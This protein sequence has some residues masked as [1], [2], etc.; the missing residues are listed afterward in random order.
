[1]TT[2][3]VEE[4]ELVLSV[5]DTTFLDYGAIKEK[6]EGYGPLGKGGN[7]SLPR[8]ALALAPENGRPLG[9]GW[10]K[11]RNRQPKPLPGVGETPGTKRRRRAN[12]REEARRRPFAEK[13]S[14]KGLEALDAVDKRVE[15]HARVIHVF[16]REGAIAEVFERVRQ[17]RHTGVLVRA[18]YN[19]SL[20]SESERLRQKMESEPIA[21]YQEID[22]PAA[23]GRKA[24]EATPAVRSRAVNSRV[25]ARF[26]N[27]DPLRVHA[28]YAVEIAPPPEKLLYLGC[29]SPPRK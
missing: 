3:A 10:Q 4:R 18:A 16:D 2:A 14:Y 6:R 21:F 13:E 28:V 26:D 1:M 20:D 23:A 27:R 7:G 29:F 8:S 24:R 22:V 25:P 19:R 17:L 15:V 11:I 12:E 9:Y 5:G